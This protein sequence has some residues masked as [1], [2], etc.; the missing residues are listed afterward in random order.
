[1]TKKQKFKT[2]YNILEERWGKDS[3]LPNFSFGKRA[4][5]TRTRS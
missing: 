1:M 2:N 4:E 5:K 3:A